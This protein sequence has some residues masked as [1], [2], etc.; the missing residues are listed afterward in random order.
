MSFNHTMHRMS[1]TPFQSKRRQFI[2][3]PLSMV[4]LL[5][6]LIGDLLRWLLGV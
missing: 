5:P 4:A 3:C 1:A 6:A 2:E